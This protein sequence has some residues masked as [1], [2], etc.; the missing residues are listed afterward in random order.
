MAI[1]VKDG[2]ATGP[3]VL[4]LRCP[5]CRHAGAFHGY[6]DCSDIGWNPIV[7]NKPN[8]TG[9]YQDINVAGMRMCPN[10][11]CGALVFVFYDPQ[12]ESITSFPPELV[13]F[14]STDLPP[15]ILAT[16]EEAVACH[17]AGAYRGA[18]LM[19][20]RLLEELCDDRGATGGNLKGRIASL[21]S[22]AVI[23]ADLLAAADE[24][25]ILGN[26]AAHVEAKDYNIIGKE[27][28]E[29]AID[30]SKELLKAVYQYS[31][32]VARLKSLA[33]KT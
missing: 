3:R 15:A 28:A 7:K 30:L 9:K 6:R 23:P 29:I 33:K 1:F 17:A 19:V 31:S 20:R 2:Q 27:E 11:E 8:G 25:R 18:A 21:S 22:V 16:L 24:L 13:D 5:V 12:S 32:L 4:N 14:D 26:D 10:H